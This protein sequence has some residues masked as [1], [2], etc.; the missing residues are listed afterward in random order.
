MEALHRK[1]TII[2]LPARFGE[3]TPVSEWVASCEII[4]PV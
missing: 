4:G 1:L 3:T 2:S